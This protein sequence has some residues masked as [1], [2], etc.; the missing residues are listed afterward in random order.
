MR[1]E[2]VLGW[3]R[4]RDDW[5]VRPIRKGDRTDRF[6]S[7]RRLDSRGIPYDCLG[8]VWGDLVYV[9]EPEHARTFD[10]V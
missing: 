1:R 9:R 7:S 5:L 2:R 3:R 8:F 4:D 10:G 6:F